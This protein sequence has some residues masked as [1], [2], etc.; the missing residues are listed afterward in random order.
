MK[1][2]AKHESSA[3]IEMKYVHNDS[4]LIRSL[5]K[6]AKKNIKISRTNFSYLPLVN[7]KRR[8]ENI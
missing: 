3:E 4:I 1:S 5:S 8:Y 2:F 7:T 6:E